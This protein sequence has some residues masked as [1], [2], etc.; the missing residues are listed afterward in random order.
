[1]MAKK[2]HAR[3]MLAAA[4]AF[5]WVGARADPAP[6]LRPDQALGLSPGTY[7]I[8]VEL[9]GGVWSIVEAG[10]EAAMARSKPAGLDP[11]APANTVQLVFHEDSKSG[12]GAMLF[13]SNGYDRRLVYKAKIERLSDHAWASTSVCPV[14][15]KMSAIENWP[16]HI[17]Q[18]DLVDIRLVENQGEI[19]CK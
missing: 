11:H 17:D 7:A 3:L 19:V 5:A 6:V 14:L 2:I 1:M 9:P 4:L 16:H 13:V 12:L 8:L 10:T 15:P 18:L